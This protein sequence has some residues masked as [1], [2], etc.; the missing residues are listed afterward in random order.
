L[1]CALGAGVLGGVLGDGPGPLG[2][3][4]DL[5]HLDEVPELE[6]PTRVDSARSFDCGPTVTASPAAGAGSPVPAVDAGVVAG[7]GV[8][9]SVG[10]VPTG[11]GVAASRRPGTTTGA[12]GASAAAGERGCEVLMSDADPTS[13]AASI[14]AEASVTSTATAIGYGRITAV[15]RCRL[16]RCRTMRRGSWPDT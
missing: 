9:V 12:V 13:T 4:G 1:G 8:G 11:G 3:D 7:A 5:R 15:E 6:P 16:T 14:G 10:A 2:V